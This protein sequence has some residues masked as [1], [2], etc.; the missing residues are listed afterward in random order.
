M[1]NKETQYIYYTHINTISAF[2]ICME[3][4]IYI[5]LYTNI[6]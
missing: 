6:E 2:S 4:I 5:I 1:N 3:Y